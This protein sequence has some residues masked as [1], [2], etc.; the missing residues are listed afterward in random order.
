MREQAL[1]TPRTWR[2]TTWVYLGLGMLLVVF[3][4]VTAW[5]WSDGWVQTW[6]PNF[7]AEWSGLLVA[8]VI[9]ERLLDRARAAEDAARRVPVRRVAGERLGRALGEL[10][11]AAVHSYASEH[12]IEREEPESAAGFLWRWAPLV[13][14]F[15]RARD[16]TWIYIFANSCE[17]AADAID[18]VRAQYL[19]ALDHDEVAD[20]DRM[21]PRLRVWRNSLRQVGGHIDPSRD[22]DFPAVVRLTPQAVAEDVGK[23]AA[24]V[25]SLFM[26]LA[27]VQRRLAG[28]ELTTKAAWESWGFIRLAVRIV[29]DSEHDQDA[30]ST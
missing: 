19:H 29:E 24:E 15:R 21:T 4:A 10:V 13:S 14:G 1:L 20:L 18:D 8:V 12:R 11:A 9:V 27:A 17:A 2:L 23:T 7:I 30:A 28:T 5:R 3:L 25:A 6:M 26:A 16:A 22:E